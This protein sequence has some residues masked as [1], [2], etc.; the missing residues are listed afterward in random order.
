[1]SMLQ[2]DQFV[3]ISHSS[4]DAGYNT[5]FV[6]G[7]HTVSVSYGGFCYGKGFRIRPNGQPDG[8]FEVCVWNNKTDET[9]LA[10]DG[11]DV[12]GWLTLAEVNDLLLHYHSCAHTIE[13]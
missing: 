12:R 11:H 10:A 13:V 1:M 5:H 3:P 6:F 8:S 9:V 7:D 4:T 2:P